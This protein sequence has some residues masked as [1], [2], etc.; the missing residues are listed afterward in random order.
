MSAR[1]RGAHAPSRAGDDA[2]VIANFFFSPGAFSSQQ[3]KIVSA[4]TPKPAREGHDLMTWVTLFPLKSAFL[5]ACTPRHFR[6]GATPFFPL[7][8]R[9]LAKSKMP[10]ST[11]KNGG[12]RTVGECYPCHETVPNACA[13]QTICG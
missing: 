3:R 11:G 1:F 4:R 9:G 2:L 8:L 13:P 6:F 5:R 10:S 12:A 7:K